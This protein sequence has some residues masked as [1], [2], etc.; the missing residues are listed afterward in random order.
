MSLRFAIATPK[1]LLI[2][3][4][5]YDSAIDTSSKES[6]VSRA[7]AVTDPRLAEATCNRGDERECD[8]I[9]DGVVGYDAVPSK[10][11]SRRKTVFVRAVDSARS[12]ASYLGRETRFT[13]LEII[14]SACPKQ[15]DDCK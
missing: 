3:K 5:S 15:I 10:S 13:A 9:G 2:Q 11:W 14:S 8:W 7:L 1:P 4:T 12:M 6:E